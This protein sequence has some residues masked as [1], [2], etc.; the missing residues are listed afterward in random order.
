[1]LIKG[2]DIVGVKVFLPEE[3]KELGQIKD[4]VYDPQKNQV[5]AFLLTEGES[6][7]DAKVIP[8]SE[9]KEISKVGIFVKS[10]QSLKKSSEAVKPIETPQNTDAIMQDTPIKTD[11]GKNLGNEHDISFDSETGMVQEIEVKNGQKIEQIQVADVVSSDDNATVIK[12][13]EPQQKQEK[14][15]EGILDKMKHLLGK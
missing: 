8:F 13:G 9:I 4:L 1:M 5:I 15:D 14:E 6:L 11:D 2:A 7:S 3:N 10:A 12:T